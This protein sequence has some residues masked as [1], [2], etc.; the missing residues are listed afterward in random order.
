VLLKSLTVCIALAQHSNHVTP[1]ACCPI[2]LRAT[3][4]CA[5][6]F[7]K[8]FDTLFN[9]HP[10]TNVLLLCCCVLYHSKQDVGFRQIKKSWLRISLAAT[11]AGDEGAAS[12]SAVFVAFLFLKLVVLPNCPSLNLACCWGSCSVGRLIH[13]RAFFH[14]RHSCCSA[15][16]ASTGGGS[17][18]DTV[19]NGK[20]VV[21]LVVIVVAC[22]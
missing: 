20:F 4:G 19:V 18:I 7:S 21:V 14:G 13:R 2:F 3:V 12:N 6:C 17:G 5:E 1:P 16:S 22:V 8:F 11:F 15:L 10:D 9:Y